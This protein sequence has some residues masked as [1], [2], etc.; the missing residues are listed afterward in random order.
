MLLDGNS[1]ARTE[2]VDWPEV[3]IVGKVT[4][5]EATPEPERPSSL[6]H[7]ISAVAGVERTDDAKC[8]RCWRHLPEVPEDGALCARCDEVVNG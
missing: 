6:E 7:S 3:L 4:V 5:T 8:G 2:G 1:Y